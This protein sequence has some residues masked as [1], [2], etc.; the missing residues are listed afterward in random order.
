MITLNEWNMNPEGL[1]YSV[2]KRKNKK[3]SLV[4]DHII[5]GARRES[6]ISMV[7]SVDVKRM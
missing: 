6:A 1:D 7:N 3:F 2:K 5:E 4:S